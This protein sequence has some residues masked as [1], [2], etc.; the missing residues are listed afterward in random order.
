MSDIDHKKG[1]GNVPPPSVQLGGDGEQKSRSTARGLRFC[2]CNS[3]MSHTDPHST[4]SLCRGHANCREVPCPEGDLFTED[5]WDELEVLV[6][7]RTKAKQIN[8][9]RKAT[10][11]ERALIA[12]QLA[13][14]EAHALEFRKQFPPAAKST[15][16][17]QAVSAAAGSAPREP[18]LDRSVGGG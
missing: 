7:R 2:K 18:S 8:A 13:Y 9:A 11:A 17:R 16:P 3:F 4:C 1:G 15:G 6:R 12:A 5:Q 10:N 14:T